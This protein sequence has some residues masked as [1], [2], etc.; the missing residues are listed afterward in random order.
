[1]EQKINTIFKNICEFNTGRDIPLSNNAQTMLVTSQVNKLNNIILFI[2]IHL[3]TILYYLNRKKN[4]S[5]LHQYIHISTLS[6]PQISPPTALPYHPLFYPHHPTPLT[7]L[8]PSPYSPYPTPGSLSS[9]IGDDDADTSDDEDDDDE[10]PTK[11]LKRDFSKLTTYS[12]P[13]PR[14]SKPNLVDQSTQAELPSRF[15]TI[16]INR[17]PYDILKVIGQGTFS[18]VSARAIFSLKYIFII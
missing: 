10:S 8:P 6:L 9:G 17:R 13:P 3:P 15:Q 18:R 7:S 12:E 2:N 5:T 16:H 1:M 11:L 14:Y 4:L